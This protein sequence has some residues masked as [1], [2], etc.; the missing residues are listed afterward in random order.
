MT[1]IE[2]RAKTPGRYSSKRDGKRAKHR[3]QRKQK[4]HTRD[5]MPPVI[6]RRPPQ[7][8]ILRP[9][10]KRGHGIGWIFSRIG[11]VI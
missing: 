8:D 5:P 2:R 3:Q 9:R 6:T 1:A 10:Y 4:N 11:E 7:A